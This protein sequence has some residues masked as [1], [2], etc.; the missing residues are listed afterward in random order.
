MPLLARTDYSVGRSDGKTPDRNP[1]HLDFVLR[2]SF[3]GR[4]WYQYV[5]DHARSRA[6]FTLRL[7]AI[8]ARAGISVTCDESWLSPQELKAE[9][10][11]F[12]ETDI[13]IARA[14]AG[15]MAANV[16]V[17]LTRYANAKPFFQHF[18]TEDEQAG[19]KALEL[20]NL[21][22]VPH[23]AVPDENWF[24]YYTRHRDAFAAYKALVTKTLRHPVHAVLATP[25]AS[26][27]VLFVAEVLQVLLGVEAS[28]TLSGT[29]VLKDPFT[30]SPAQ[31]TWLRDR[32]KD[33]H[34]H[35]FKNH[36]RAY[37]KK[38]CKAWC[39]LAKAA[40][41]SGGDPIARKQLVQFLTPAL[42]TIGL[43]LKAWTA[44]GRHRAAEG[45]RLE[46]S[47]EQPVREGKSRVQPP[48][49][50]PAFRAGSRPV[51]RTRAESGTQQRRRS[52]ARSRPV[53]RTRAE[54]GTQQRRPVS[55]DSD[56]ET[57]SET[58]DR[59][60]RQRQSVLGQLPFSSRIIPFPLPALPDWH[61][62]LCGAFS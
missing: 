44:G 46:F 58:A 61:V 11:R 16:P 15:R 37:T 59:I 56:F 48:E 24:W 40:K 3:E 60:R 62:L 34:A 4:C 23:G 53:S 27:Q 17:A 57:V 36:R 10:I 19:Q 50:L 1:D 12:A 55:S 21:F 49:P 29:L 2:E 33:F 54:A 41:R 30:L 52:R 18:A 43:V 35:D 14:E 31:L 6:A 38:S 45:Y 26:Q 39:G 47:W 8:F 42:K 51:S 32:A 13:V 20:M 7:G 22:E 28:A 9:R 5:V 25:T